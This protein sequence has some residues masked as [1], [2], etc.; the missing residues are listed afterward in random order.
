MKHRIVALALPLIA[1]AAAADLAAG[2]GV[3]Q[4]LPLPN[5]FFPG[6]VYVSDDGSALCGWNGF[7][8]TEATGYVT[9][10]AGQI[11]GVS[12][13]G[14]TVIGTATDPQ[15]NEVA[16]TW[17]PD[18]NWTPLPVADG[19]EACGA[20]ISSGW[21][22]N[23]DAT[24]AVGL[25]WVP[26]CRA[27]AFRAQGGS[28][29]LLGRSANVSSRASD[30]SGDGTV[31]VGFDESPDFGFR[32]PAFWTADVEGPQY[33]TAPDVAGELLGVNGDGTMMCG[34]ANSSAFFY[35]PSTGLIDIGALPG[36]TWGSTA[37][38]VSDNGRVV[39][40]SGNPFFS[41]PSATIWTQDAGL[42]PLAS[43][44]TAMSVDVGGYHLY[45]ATSISADGYT[46][47]GTAIDPTG[48][49]FVPYVVRL[50]HVDGNATSDVGDDAPFAVGLGVAPNPTFGA[51]TISFALRAAEEA[52]VSVVDLTGRELLRLA[53]RR[54][55]AGSHPITWDGLDA[56]G[57]SLPS[58]TYFVRIVT[59]GGSETRKLN[60]VR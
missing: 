8:W 7:Y 10:P 44:L 11:S 27:E 31:V 14:S 33:I 21:A 52:R 46:I 56:S 55:E 54:F 5:S 42:Q 60:L 25:T 41:F 22:L 36:E 37:T 50:P 20:S 51:T 32:R 59:P 15:G 40:W 47:A 57:R 12:G 43:Y 3:F 28:A 45:T 18:G 48:F 39:G 26:G 1:A 9:L 58:G 49:W 19:G 29:V 34:E 4:P 24:V 17:T 35:S 13:D 2:A 16:A 6:A 30:V 23:R 53:D 38:G